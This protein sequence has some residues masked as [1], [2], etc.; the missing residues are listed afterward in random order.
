MGGIC[1]FAPVRD[2]AAQRTVAATAR[3]DTELRATDELLARPVTMSV[4]AVSLKHAINAA[5][6][7]TK[8]FVQY[9]EPVVDAYRARVTVTL[10]SVPLQ[11]AFDKILAGTTLRVVVPEGTSE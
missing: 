2:L 11:A 4:T 8:V 5:A 3:A 6:T 7:S 10:K 1:A 9:R